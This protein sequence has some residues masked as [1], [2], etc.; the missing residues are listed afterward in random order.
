MPAQTKLAM[1]RLSISIF[2]VLAGLGALIY[3]LLVALPP[4]SPGLIVW[5]I[6]TGFWVLFSIALRKTQIVVNLHL[7]AVMIL[8]VTVAMA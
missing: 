7:T 6:I 2:F 5:G 8:F 4:E 3:G 1:T